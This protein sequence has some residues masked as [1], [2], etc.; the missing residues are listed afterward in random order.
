MQFLIKLAQNANA[1]WPSPSSELQASAKA[2][3]ANLNAHLG[4]IWSKSPSTV[5]HPT[6]TRRPPPNPKSQPR[7]SEREKRSGGYERRRRRPRAPSARAAPSPPWSSLLPSFSSPIHRSPPSRRHCYR[8]SLLPSPHHRSPPSRRHCYR[9][10]SSHRHRR[11]PSCC[12]RIVSRRHRILSCRRRIAS[13]RHQVSSSPPPPP[14]SLS[15]WRRHR[16]LTT[17]VKA[18]GRLTSADRLTA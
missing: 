10:M 11:I 15:S 6:E 18:T 5:D 7:E 3:A 1:I 17:N 16:R 13:R 14:L 2:W 9:R 8:H 4:Q 12:R